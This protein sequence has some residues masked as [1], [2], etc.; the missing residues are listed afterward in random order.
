MFGV[1]LDL[2]V[3]DFRRVL[4]RPRPVL[5]GLF[6]HFVAGPAVA[7]LL[8]RLLTPAPSVALGLMLV[9]ACPAGNISNFL[10]HLSKGNTAL[11]VS[12]SSCS[13]VLAV[14]L[15]PLN[16][17]F[18]AGLYPPTAALLRDVAVDPVE[19]FATIF[20]LLG[21][22]LALGLWVGR[23]FPAFRHR[24]RKTM[25]VVALV[26][27]ALFVIVAT[28]ANW[29]AFTT[30][31]GGVVIAVGTYNAAAYASGYT[32]AALFQL[33]ERDRRAIAMEVGVQ[34]SGL[35]MILAFTFF[36][37]LGGMAL[38]CAWWGVWQILTGLALGTWW[39]RR[40]PAPA[41]E[42]AAVAT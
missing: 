18:W 12:I 25:K 6:G 30:V 23:R 28:V 42:H 33:G 17:R 40:P 8:V 21:I 13:T 31:L 2:D 11:S 32:T 15:T 7:Y 36:D 22:P 37:G 34:N 38:T 29:H 35:G 19:M 10:A 3:A 4:D 5:I 20:I 14:V 16:L 9:A 39:S 41:L 24:A 1:A 27:F 26:V